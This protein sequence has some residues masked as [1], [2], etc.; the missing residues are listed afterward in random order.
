VN[1][2]DPST[3][4]FKL[5]R[6]SV[7]ALRCVRLGI[8]AAL[9]ASLFLVSS[10]EAEGKFAKEFREKVLKRVEVSGYRRLSLHNHTVTG[11]RDAYNT[12]NYFGQG[13]KKFTDI[14]QVDL[15]GR[16]VLGLFNFDATIL[17]SRVNDPQGQKLSLDYKDKRL[18]VNAGDIYGSL[19]NSNRYASYA[20]SL[21]GVQGSYRTGSLTTKVLYT[22][23]RGTARTVSISGTNSAGPYFLQN[24]QIIRGSEKIQLDGVSM[25]AGTDYVVDYDS[26]SI[27]FLGRVVPPTSTIVAS[28]EALGFGTKAGTVQG[29]GVSLNMGKS[30]KVGI[31]ALQQVSRSGGQGSTRL[32]KFEGFGA[33]STPY[34]LQFEPISTASVTIRV[35]GIVQVLGVDFRFDGS[36]ASVFY[37][38]R[39]MAATDSI[40]VVYTPKP[41]TTVEGDRDVFG[42]DY[43]LPIG[44]GGSAGSLSLYQALG[45][46]KNTVTPSKGLARGASLN[47]RSKD[48]LFTA[49]YRDVPTG[50]V[51]I[52][53]VGFQRNEKAYDVGVELTPHPQWGY[54][55]SSGNSVVGV[56]TATNSGT[57]VRLARVTTSKASAT[58]TTPT[59]LNWE[60]RHERSRSRL[61]SGDQY[62]DTSSI[63]GTQ[64]MG[65]VDLRIGLN[66]TM[67]GSRPNNGSPTTF[68]LDGIELAT[69]YTYR[70]VLSFSGRAETSRVTVNRERGEGKDYELTGTY[71]PS[72][73]FSISSRYALS[74]SGRQLTQFNFNNGLGIGFD[75]N[76]FSG[77]GE[78]TL[79]GGA[80][81]LELF[82]M[83]SRYE[84]ASWVS[85]NGN[86][87]DARTSG[88]VTSNSRTRSTGLNLEAQGKY[89]HRLSVG[90]ST[91]NT[92]FVGSTQKSGTD[93]WNVYLDGSPPG[94]TSYS[95]GFTLFDTAG[96][97]TFSQDSTSINANV[98]YRIAGRHSLFADLFSTRSTGY[99]PQTSFDLGLGYRYDLTRDIG[100]VAQWKSRR[101]RNSGSQITSGAYTSNGFDLT[102]DVNF[103]P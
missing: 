31:T 100:F 61:T 48:A 87:Q 11:D 23:A 12:G 25:V 27:T 81:N 22:Q 79:L 75:G 26:G 34:F 1:A 83:N 101:I 52:E 86:Y 74:D 9:G 91:F 66:R 6:L 92:T 42:I 13:Q 44:K 15:R 17:D 46:L 93:A 38:N 37:F 71:T 32:E 89:N 98:G 45:R 64:R 56:R 76:G 53:T 57:V 88:S 2:S 29:M 90:F 51:G 62:A 8:P 50:Y 10:A 21:R 102:F 18:T 35:N 69:A 55:I 16:N 43:E 77:G 72:R 60:A 4:N 97:S 94:R 30:G 33:P 95:L 82:S 7:A 54:K 14:G 80:S 47:V 58:F 3:Q 63:Y 85:L 70:G 5:P 103:R 49:T 65:S 67:G 41:R 28:Y 68:L 40:D 39:F 96:A 59:G 24:N 36:N 84:L 19:I 73:R 20:R 78:S 99:L